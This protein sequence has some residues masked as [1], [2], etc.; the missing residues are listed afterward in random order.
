MEMI[1]DA[2]KMTHLP[3]PDLRCC[4][5]SCMSSIKTN[6]TSDKNRFIKLSEGA[7]FNYTT[8]P[9]LLLSLLCSSCNWKENAK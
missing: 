5:S 1:C 3:S 2:Q 8:S 7:Y 9:P 6:R 4:L